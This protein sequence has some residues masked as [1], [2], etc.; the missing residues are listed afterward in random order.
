MSEKLNATIE[1]GLD[2]SKVQ[3]GV[4]PIARTIENLSKVAKKASKETAD[5]V[6]SIGDSGANAS[7]KIDRATNNMIG[8]I[9]RTTAAMESGSKSSAKYFEVLAQQRGINL[10]TLRP[11]IDRKSV[12]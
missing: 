5:S 1:V 9:Q 11:Y 7:G 4:A 10:D 8:S 3:E 2:G 12:V 6:E